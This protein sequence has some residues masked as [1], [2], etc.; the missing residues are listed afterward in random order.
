M[1]TG[2]DAVREELK[3]WDI[4]ELMFGFTLELSLSESEN[5][6]EGLI[7]IYLEMIEKKLPP[8]PFSELYKSYEKFRKRVFEEYGIELLPMEEEPEK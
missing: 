4:E 8:M 1:P 2:Y 5:F 3:G 7:S 6:D